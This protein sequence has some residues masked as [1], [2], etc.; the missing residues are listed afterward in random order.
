MSQY[1]TKLSETIEEKIRIETKLA[2]MLKPKGRKDALEQ[3]R[4]RLVGMVKKL[5]DDYLNKGTVETRIYENMIK[6][7][8]TRLAEVE[9]Q[10]TFYDAE[11]ALAENKWSNRLVKRIG[12]KR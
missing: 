5:Q 7:Y 1:E 2:N 11:Q 12:G 6:S 4:E 8:S 10:L 3:E 9:E